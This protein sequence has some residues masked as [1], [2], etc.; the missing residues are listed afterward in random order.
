MDGKFYI[1]DHYFAF[2]AT[3]KVDLNRMKINSEFR[4]VMRH[5]EV[6]TIKR[7]PKSVKGVVFTDIGQVGRSVSSE[8]GRSVGRFMVYM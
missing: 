3:K 1:T 7:H 5:D 6:I 2:S 4:D 8:V